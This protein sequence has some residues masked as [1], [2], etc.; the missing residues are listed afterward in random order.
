MLCQYPCSNNLHIPTVLSDVDLIS[1]S[2]QPMMN[3]N[4]RFRSHLM[5]QFAAAARNQSR[6]PIALARASVAIKDQ[7]VR[8]PKESLQLP[9]PRFEQRSF[10]S[11]SA[12]ILQSDNDN[13]GSFKESTLASREEDIPQPTLELEESH[14]AIETTSDSSSKPRTSRKLYISS[15]LQ[16][17]PDLRPVLDRAVLF[18]QSVPYHGR[19][20]DNCSFRRLLSQAAIDSL[21]TIAYHVSF[22]R[23]FLKD[24]EGAITFAEG[25]KRKWSQIPAYLVA[26]VGNQPATEHVEV[27]PYDELPFVPPVSALQLEDVSLHSDQ[28][29]Q[30]IVANAI[31]FISMLHLT[32]P[33]TTFRPV[34]T[35]KGLKP[36]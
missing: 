8:T 23:R 6:P 15:F 16:L 31:F 3:S 10:T 34:W 26:L 13:H 14:D 28:S 7:F 5:Q 33:C 25:K 21:A 11:S 24:P 32:P 35:R 29:L 19:L 18:A 36:S 2:Q 12:S 27:N 1:S 20:T 22:Q 30:Q 9:T 4:G 17:N